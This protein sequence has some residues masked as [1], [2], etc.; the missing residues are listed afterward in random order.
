MTLQYSTWGLAHG[1]ISPPMDLIARPISHTARFASGSCG[2]G[3]AR[4]ASCPTGSSSPQSS[5][6]SSA[7]CC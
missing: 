6:M 4:S 1:T 7:H 2:T 3:G 5:G